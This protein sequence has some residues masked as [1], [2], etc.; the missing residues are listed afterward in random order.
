MKRKL[1]NKSHE[2]T[3]KNHTVVKINLGLELVYLLAH[4]RNVCEN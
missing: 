1:R 3:K 2:E 4:N